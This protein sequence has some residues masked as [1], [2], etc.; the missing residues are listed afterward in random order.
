[1][2][3]IIIIHLFL[4]LLIITKDGLESLI[5][6]FSVNNIIQTEKEKRNRLI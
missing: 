6:L 3:N 5:R 1:M 4:S 2:I